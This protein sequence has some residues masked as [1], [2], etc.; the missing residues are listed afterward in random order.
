[1]KTATITRERA[2]ELRKLCSPMF[3]INPECKEFEPETEAER[4][5]VKEIWSQN[6]SGYS[7]YHSTLCDIEQGRVEG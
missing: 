6:P 7:C 2:R 5:R 4:K 1:M 3:F